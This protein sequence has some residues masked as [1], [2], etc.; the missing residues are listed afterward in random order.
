MKTSADV[1]IIGGGIIGCATAYNLARL[2]CS[3][4]VVL[5]KNT[6]GS[7][8][9]SRAAGGIRVQF[10]TPVHI[11]FSLRSMETWERFQDE[12]GVDV[13]YRRWGYL[14]LAGDEAELDVY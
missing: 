4:V 13:D 2:G 10:S 14:F 6:V 7:G 11:Q 8:S 3:N 1:A 9:T 12:F 5:E